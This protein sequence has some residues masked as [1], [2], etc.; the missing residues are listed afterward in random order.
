MRDDGDRLL[1]GLWLRNE[2]HQMRAKFLPFSKPC[3]REEDIAAVGDVLRSGWIT[4]G[5][6]AA[7]LEQRFAEKIGC[8]GALAVSSATGGMHVVLAALGIGP[9]DEVLTPSLTWVSTVNL[10]ELAGATPVFVDVD[11]ETLMAPPEA[12]ARAITPRT[13]AMIPVHYA[14][15]ACD[16][17]ALRRLAAARGIFLIEDAAHGMGTFHRGEHVGARGTSIFSFHAIKNLTTAEGGMICTD[18]TE[19]F[20]RLKRLKFH[21]LGV[22][23]FDRSMQGRAPQAEVLEPGYKYNL[24]DLAAVLGLC[25]LERIDAMNARRAE[26]AAL[27][28]ERLARIEEVRPL[29]LPSYPQQHAWHLFVVRVD[30]EALGMDRFAFM[31]ELKERNIGTGVH[32]R[33]AHTQR[34]YRERYRFPPG[35]LP[36]TEWN[37]ERICSLPLFPDMRDEDVEDVATAIEEV[38]RNSRVLR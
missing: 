19:L 11:R 18:D 32:F 2:V 8:K 23:A 33:A 12:Y 9:G 22:D 27:Y 1:S 36:N 5:P 14:G 38:V 20:Q 29:G 35:F 7:E 26:I 31:A 4:T 25:Q 34:Y 17:E 28:H 21:G 24:P 6:K 10:I 3:I 16:I 13:K 15:A 37:S 30:I